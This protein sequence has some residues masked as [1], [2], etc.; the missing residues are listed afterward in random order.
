MGRSASVG[1]VW[2][3][4]EDSRDAAGGALGWADKLTLAWSYPFLLGGAG[5]DCPFSQP[6][7]AYY[8]MQLEL[9]SFG[10]Y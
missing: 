7:T 2:R 5:V 3:R 4:C 6:G 10:F 8:T 9:A 1:A